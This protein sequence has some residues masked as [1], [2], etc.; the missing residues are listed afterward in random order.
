MIDP[1]VPVTGLF[2]SATIRA[3]FI[4]ERGM[5]VTVVG[6]PFDGVGKRLGDQLAALLGEHPRRF[7]SFRAS[8]AFVK[9]SGLTRLMAG[10]QAFRHA[11][12][13]VQFVAGIDEGITS[14]QA[15]ELLLVNSDSA[16]VFHNPGSSFH[17]KVY[18]LE[19][20][21]T[22][23]MFVGSGNTTAGGLFTNCE[24]S[25]RVDLDLATEA[26]KAVLLPM[27]AFFEHLENAQGNMV[28]LDR[29]FL[30]ELVGRDALDDETKNNKPGG[31]GGAKGNNVAS[32]FKRRHVPPAPKV[33]AGIA[34]AAFAPAAVVP[35]APAALA[36]IAV[37][38]I[39]A[40][41]LGA[42]D[43]RHRA[44]YSPDIFIPKIGRDADPGFWG[45]PD[46][47][48]V[49]PRPSKGHYNE[50]FLRL[51][52]RPVN[53]APVVLPAVRLY[54]YEEKKEFRLN[55]GALV[56]GANEGDILTLE[57]ASDDAEFGGQPYEYEAIVVPKAHSMFP[58][59]AA[60]AS[61]DVEAGNSDKKWGYQ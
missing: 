4:V 7:E 41:T 12:G 55:C 34:N 56:R 9:A 58:V 33:P 17:P 47:F 50:R 36:A 20:L 25:L 2:A 43:T 54:W 60:V 61:N 38:R 59:W 16:Y 3:T 21:D 19:G 22:A 53:G 29:A 26:D 49:P 8:V 42:R 30:D 27:K 1:H 28:L 31:G 24:A 18:L 44:G 5:I 40:M 6:Q 45:W 23:T 10:I 46:K 32:L 15:L 39:F 11:G 48:V 52:I 35:P 13:T 57:A 14:R 37:N 51:L